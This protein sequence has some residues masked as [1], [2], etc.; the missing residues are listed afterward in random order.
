MQTLVARRLRWAVPFG[1]GAA[2]AA[3]AILPGVA[4]GSD[5]PNLPARSAQQ[6]LSDVLQVRTAALSGTVVETARLGLPEL[7]TP[8]GSGSA[9]L[10]WTN[11]LSG[12]HTFRVWV[13]GPE[14]QRVALVGELAESDY[15]HDG[16]SLWLYSSSANRATKVTVPSD[17]GESARNAV[18]G[19]LPTPAEAAAQAI[20]A[21]TPTTTVSV[22]DT[23]RVAGRPAYQL[24]L[25]PKDTRSLI[26]KV[27]IAV[28]SATS[29]PLRVQVYA[30]GSDTPAF[31]TGFTDVTF[32]TPPA[33]VFSFIPPTGAQVQTATAGDVLSG[34][35]PAGDGAVRVTAPGTAPGTATD[36]SRAVRTGEGQPAQRIGSGW[37]AVYVTDLSAL[38][39]PGS[40]SLGSLQSILSSSTTQVAGGRLLSTALLS[41]LITNQGRV[42]VGAVTPAALEQ[43]AATGKPL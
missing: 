35:K 26:G 29:V 31:E 19:H 13:D 28:D 5:H 16:S 18:T 43:V 27:T 42:Y 41:V 7:P 40:G 30:R 22:D 34:R 11:L 6:L 4:A 21:L 17:A 23:A 32:A 36:K 12:S 9:D 10:S 25:A 14:K 8:A 33:S 37:T 24:V 15:V 2:I 39:G 38:G 3:A 1:A 20:A